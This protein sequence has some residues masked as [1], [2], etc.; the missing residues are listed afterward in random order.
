MVTNLCYGLPYK[1]VHF[2]VDVF[3]W[4]SGQIFRMTH[5][6]KI[7]PCQKQLLDTSISALFR[8]IITLF[9][10]VFLL[11]GGRGHGWSIFHAKSNFYLR[12]LSMPKFYYLHLMF[13]WLC[14]WLII[15]FFYFILTF[16]YYE[17]GMNPH[18]PP[19]TS[20]YLK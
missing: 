6:D 1:N 16:H 2:F 5:S 10:V 9:Y 3:V 14:L 13:N 12:N 17:P 4:N 11:K 18:W 7:Y 19:M 15:C 20:L 8:V